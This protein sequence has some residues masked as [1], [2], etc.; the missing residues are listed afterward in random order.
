MTSSKKKS[1]PVEIELKYTLTRSEC[2]R[3]KRFL[4]SVPHKNKT[5][6]NYYFDS[7][8]LELRKKKIGLR[9]RTVG[10][11]K[12]IVTIKFPKP[13]KNSISSLKVRYEYEAPISTKVAK[14]ILKGKKGIETL[15]IKPIVVLKSKTPANLLKR[16]SCLG[17]LKTKRTTY[18]YHKDFV[19]E[20]DDSTS[21]GKTFYELEAETKNP[22][23]TDAE[24]RKLLLKANVKCR[25][26]E[27]SKLQR[28][29][30]EW[31]QQKRTRF[32]N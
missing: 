20:L 12:A 16:L 26:E 27:T 5:Q 11:Q 14:E 1:P 30:K 10:S 13:S 2:L 8:A 21:F 28:F 6:T 24:I 15:R 29:L 19:L 18:Q 7:P 31:K 25:P 23:N 17:G 22:K 4:N 32:K 9:I 3:L